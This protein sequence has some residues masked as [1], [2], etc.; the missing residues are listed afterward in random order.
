VVP[1]A[2][3]G[4]DA[5][6]FSELD[7]VIEAG[8]RTALVGGSGSGKST[9]IA[10]CERFYDVTAGAITLD[11]TD[12]RELSIVWLR[13]QIGLVSQVCLFASTR[14]RWFPFKFV[15]AR[16]GLTRVG[17]FAQEPVLF[18]SATRGTI[19][20]NVRYGKPDATQEEVERACQEANCAEFIQKLPKGYDTCVGEAG[21]QLSGGQK[22]RIAIARAIIRNPSLMLLDEATSALDTGE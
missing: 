4:K 16:R 10:L 9:V 22:Q 7:L 17:W 21:T 18:G 19:A 20:E 11:G 1:D 15:V 3:A 13:Q 5:L 8:Q 12:I 2:R 14:L 6:I